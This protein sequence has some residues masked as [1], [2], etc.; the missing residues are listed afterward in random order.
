MN[1]CFLCCTLLMAMIQVGWSQTAPTGVW[2]S[3][4]PETNKPQSHIRIFEDDGKIHG[5]VVKLFR[6][7]TQNPH[8]LC[9]ACEPDDPRYNQPVLGMTLMQDLKP[10]NAEKWV[11]GQVLDPDTGKEYRC[12]VELETPDTMKVRAY[13]GFSLLGRTKYLYRQHSSF[14]QTETAE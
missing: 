14:P 10:K 12:Y 7:S 2:I 9:K 6:D 11:D 8:P 5:K 3:V 1:R 4:D 13:I